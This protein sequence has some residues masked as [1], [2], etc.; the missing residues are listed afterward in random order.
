MSLYN[1]AINRSLMD[2]FTSECHDILIKFV[3]MEIE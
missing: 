2:P 3:N 1:V